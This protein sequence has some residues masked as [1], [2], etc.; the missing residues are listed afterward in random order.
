M[1]RASGIYSYCAIITLTPCHLDAYT[2]ALVSIIVCKGF[3]ALAQ[4]TRNACYYTIRGVNGL[5]FFS[6]NYTFPLECINCMVSEAFNMNEQ[7]VGRN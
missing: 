7:F 2:C 4:G 6:E 3:Q 5:I 1:K